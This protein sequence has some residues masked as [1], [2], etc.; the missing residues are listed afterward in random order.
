[1][2]DIVDTLSRNLRTKGTYGFAN[3]KNAFR[4]MDLNQ[5][6]YIEPQEFRLGFKRC[7]IALSDE[8]FKAVLAGFDQDG[9]GRIDY[10]EF[11]R[12]LNVGHIKPRITSIRPES[13]KSNK[14]TSF[15][16]KNSVAK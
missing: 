15:C 2:A 10:Q 7:G 1:M 5:N 9:N 16:S 13:S 14:F 4:D 11:V 3:L 6:G 12:A 8:D